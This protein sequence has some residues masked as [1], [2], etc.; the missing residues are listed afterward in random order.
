MNRRVP[1]GLG[2]RIRV[3]HII[4]GLNVGG[5]ELML[6]RLIKSHQ[7]NPNCH[8]SVISLTLVGKVGAQLQEMGVEVRA[9]GM[10]SPLD[11][12]RVLWQLVRGIRA[13]RPD[14][15]QTW[16]YHAD[17]LGGM[18]ARLAGN[19]RVI[20]GVRGSAIPKGQLATRL[21]VT[22][23]SWLS[24]LLP[25]VI[26]CCAESAR[27]AHAEK[28]YDKSKFVV[29]P[30]GY[31]LSHF[32][33]NS[34]L[35]QQARATF[36][37]SNDDV[38]VG[39]IG[40]FDP[41]KDHRNFVLAATIVASKVNH[42]KFL[43]I[44]R[45]I[46]LENQVLKAWLTEGGFAHKFVLMGELSNIP[47]CLAAMDIFCL[48]SFKEGFPN[49][50]CEAMAMNVPCVV[51]DAGDAAEIVSD[52]GIVVAASD[53]SALADALQT[54]ISKDIFERLHLGELARLR[55]EKNY[56]IE[57]A[58]SRFENLYKQVA[59]NCHLNY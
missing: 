58:S 14:I 12:P 21:V 55:I 23:C 54:M 9:L 34:I 20:W 27:L 17:L 39:I 24:R 31:D 32:N 45:D 6:K 2:Y 50:I 40:R 42:V 16:M 22:L 41:L 29:I 11:I 28:G 35:R 4:I 7:G 33:R 3:L 53:A 57:I 30:N 49:V 46:D 8:H 13:G 56:S 5:A 51:T 43:M 52:T 37:F 48:S 36:G 10:R 25:R 1:I 47:E 44:G 18:A 38:V 15:V 19:R 59:N 26:V